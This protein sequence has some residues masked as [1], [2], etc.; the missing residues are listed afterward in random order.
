MCSSMPQARSLKARAFFVKTQL[1]F[2]KTL[3]TIRAAGEVRISSRRKLIGTELDHYLKETK[4]NRNI[5]R[6]TA[7]MN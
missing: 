2:R 4:T 1:K 5:R 6:Q 3:T 7:A